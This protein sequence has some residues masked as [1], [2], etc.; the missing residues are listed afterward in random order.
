MFTFSSHIYMYHSKLSSA[1][2][3]IIVYVPEGKFN[4]INRHKTFWIDC[5]K[6]IILFIY[7]LGAYLIFRY[8]NL[9]NRGIR[10]ESLS[11]ICHQ[12]QPCLLLLSHCWS[13]LHCV[14]QSNCLEILLFIDVSVE[15]TSTQ[16]WLY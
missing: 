9:I 3:F 14:G 16:L 4:M 5:F 15:H 7:S 2:L 10:I 12:G 11:F 6:R 13:D 1:F 8:I